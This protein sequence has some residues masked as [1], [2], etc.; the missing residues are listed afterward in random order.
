MAGLG[1]EPGARRPHAPA[2]TSSTWPAAAAR[3]T[4]SR[5]RRSTSARRRSTWRAIVF[6]T[7]AARRCRRGHLRARPERADLHVPAA[8]RL[9]D[10]VLA[11]RDRGRLARPGVHPGRPLPVQREEVRRRPGGDDRGDPQG[12]Q[13]SPSP[14]A[15]ATSTSTP[16]RW[17]TCR[18]PTVDEQQRE[19]YRRAAELTALIRELEPDGVTIS[20]GGEIGEV[21]KKNSTV[22][23]LRRLPRRL[24][25]RARRAGRR[26][27]PG[28]SQ[29][30][31]PDRHEPR[32]RAAARTAASPRSSSIS[33]CCASSARSLART[34]SRA[35]SSTA[36]RRCPTSC[37]I[38]SRRSR[39]PRSTSRPG[40]RTRSTS[41]R[42]SRRSSTSE[43]EALVLR[44][45]GRRAQAR[46]D[47]RAVRLHD[48]Q[49]GDRPVQAPA[50]GPAD[51]GR[52]PRRA[53]PQVLVPVHRAR[54]ERV[55][56]RW[57]TAYVRP[58]EVHRPV[59]DRSR[60]L[61]PPVVR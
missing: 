46:P 26:A 22:E 29:G 21:G 30:Q 18:K 14:P 56:A 40:S 19:N 5:C 13:R 43:I 52:D 61:P 53:A 57:S 51:E 31:R 60:S 49:E 32:R 38:A 42:R 9:R 8:D 59:P 35:P 45:R 36:P 33:R 55:A 12:L 11:G 2:S 7:A 23:E 10:R 24:P 6:E 37:S 25:P 50:V 48:P 41:T 1:G 20:V 17:S 58:V 54:R 15:T 47:R 16:R 44:E 27:R 39:P 34:A 3:S 28:I 4:A